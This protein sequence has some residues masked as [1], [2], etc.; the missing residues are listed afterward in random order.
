[1]LSQLKFLRLKRRPFRLELF[2]MVGLLPAC[3]SLSPLVHHT[4]PLTTEQHCQLGATYEAQG[5]T[6]L[7]REQY[8][9][10]FRQ[11]KRSIPVLIAR[12]NLAFGSG[13][14]KGAE[15]DYRRVLKRDR[16]HAG[17]NNN[18]AMVHLK[19][20]GPLEKAQ[21]LAQMAVEQEGAV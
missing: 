14:L 7:A 18:L 2:W 8:D 4:D 5:L 17:A 1:M 12:G 9:A 21:R 16:K 3:A 13:D 19:R 20:G 15:T 10:A 11:D 6:A